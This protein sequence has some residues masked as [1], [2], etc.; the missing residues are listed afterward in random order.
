V[1]IQDK[2]H[3]YD[4]SDP[5]R[6]AVTGA[7]TK[8]FA[9]QSRVPESSEIVAWSVKVQADDPSW[10][11]EG[12]ILLVRWNEPKSTW[13]LLYLIKGPVSGG[14]WIEGNK[15]LA[16]VLEWSADFSAEPT[17]AETVRFLR[18]TNFGNNEYSYYPKVL[19]VFAYKKE[20]KELLQELTTGIDI[21]EK[22][23]RRNA[24]SQRGGRGR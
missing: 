1:E 17:E 22:I 9:K 23:R 19:K 11:S 5:K 6:Q 14:T 21:K 2:D 18:T 7:V 10:L 15:G 16:H 3:A 20:W 12:L 4:P 8:L 24:T 13:S